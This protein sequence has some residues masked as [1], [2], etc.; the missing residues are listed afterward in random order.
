VERLLEESVE[1]GEGQEAFVASK[2]KQR[3]FE[4]FASFDG[5]VQA[6]LIALADDLV[7]ADG[8]LH[9]AEERLRQELSD[10]LRAPAQVLLVPDALPRPV[11]VAIRDEAVAEPVSHAIFDLVEAHYAADDAR[12]EA[13]LDEDCRLFAQA[14]AIHDALRARG[15]GRLLGAARVDDLDHGTEVLDES[16]HVL[17]PR[18]GDRVEATVVGDLHGCYSNLKAAVTQS[19]F[20]E[21]VDAYRRDPAASPRPLL[22]LLGDYL[23]RGDLGF[24]GALRLAVRLFVTYPEHVRLLRGNHEFY[25]EYADDVKSTVVPAEG[26]DRWKAIAHLRHL[27]AAAQLFEDLPTSMILGRT[28]LTH[29][30]VPRDTLTR[31]K[32]GDLAGLNDWNVRF[33]MMWSDPSTVDVVPKALQDSTYRFAF[34]RLQCLGFLQRVGCHTFIRGHEHVEPGYRVSWDD[35]RMLFVTVVSAGGATNADL[36]PDADLRLARPR[37]LTLLHYGDRDGRSEIEIWPL[38]YGPFNLGAHN[39]FYRSPPEIPF[40]RRPGAGP[41][42]S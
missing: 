36:P 33:Q 42:G 1:H 21:K 37:A 25:V 23:D 7:L 19:R 31:E 20:L 3:C 6:Q 24:E 22:V 40:A 2:L 38:D 9:P 30:G 12:R 14:T 16:V 26:R 4:I 8:D 34:G 10:L 15:P 28:F 35:D 17:Q 18:P 41:V 29:G 13:Q 5:P 39:G 32:L 11:T 27:R